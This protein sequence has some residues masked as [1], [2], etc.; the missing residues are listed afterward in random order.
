MV[1]FFGALS[2][3]AGHELVHYKQ[4]YYKLLGNLP[5]TGFFYT[6]FWDEHN[7]NHHVNLATPLD[8]VCAEVGQNCY[9]ALF[10]SVIG[11]HVKSWAREIERLTKVNGEDLSTFVH[12]TQN[13]MVHYQIVHALMLLFIY[14]AFGIGGVLAQF[15]FVFLGLFW[16]EMLNYTEHY[17][18]RRYK[19]ES[20][21]YESIGYVHSWSTN[22]S[23]TTFRISR[24][25]DHHAHKFRPYQV[26][27]RLDRAPFW[28]FE[29]VPMILLALVP[30]MWWYLMDPMVK[31]LED[32]KKGIP[33][34]DSWNAE[35]PPSEA[36]F[37]RR[38]NTEI[39]FAGLTFLLT[40]LLFV[41]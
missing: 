35:T 19:D 12:L 31:S 18:L 24:H 38:T 4:W 2:S 41:V 8:P 39:F 6:H 36:D 13:R 23:A 26:M 9:S 17:G 30:P 33:N 16:F 22:S 34:P 10:N 37:T 40:G 21:V 11:T 1:S 3:V 28:P 25:S 15:A 27:R 29:L 14:I 7:K 5:Y 20:G 32:T